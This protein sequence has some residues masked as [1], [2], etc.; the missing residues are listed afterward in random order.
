MRFRDKVA[1]VTGAA[2]GIGLATAKRLGSEGARV[3]IADLKGDA[4]EKSAE[5][6]RQAGAPDALGMACD[7]SS[8]AQ[9]AATVKAAMDRFGRL[10]V[11]V[12]NAGLMTF[13]SLEDSP[14]RTGRRSSMSICSGRC[15]SPSRRS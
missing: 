14:Q 2:G 4:A 13:K 8:E 3:I 12:N 1:I 9:V 15:T 6:V 5:S 7:V 11:V 10:D